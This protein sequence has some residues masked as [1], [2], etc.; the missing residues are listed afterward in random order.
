MPSARLFVGRNGV[1]IALPPRGLSTREC[2]DVHGS[3]M[4]RVT[5]TLHSLCGVLVRNCCLS[6]AVLLSRGPELGDATDHRLTN[7]GWKLGG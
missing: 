3:Q 2:F 5:F 7:I 1:N 6:K 4:A